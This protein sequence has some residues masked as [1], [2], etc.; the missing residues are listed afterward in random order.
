MSD[1]NDNKEYSRYFVSILPPEIDIEKEDIFYRDKYNEIINYFKLILT[2]SEDLEVYKY[3]KPKGVLLI[4]VPPGTDIINY[5]KLICSNYYLEFVELNNLE[6][7]KAPKD[8]FT[9]FN[10]ILE[11]F[12]KDIE[13]D[14]LRENEDKKQNLDKDNKIKLIL[15]NQ[16]STFNKLFKNESLLSNYINNIQYNQK[17]KGFI[18]NNLILVWLSYDYEEI[19]EVSDDLYEFFDLFIKI[20]LLNK[21]ERETVL[22]NFSEKNQKIAFDINAIVN[23]TENWEVQDLT[24]LLKIGIFKHYLKFEFNDVSNEITD[25]LIN[26]IET[27]EYISSKTLIESKNQKMDIATQEIQSNLSKKPEIDKSQGEF[28]KDQEA[29]IDEIKNQKVSEFM[30]NQLYENAASKNYNELL[31]IIDKLNNKEIIEDNDRK[32]IAKYP[33]ILNDTP[34]R[35]QLNLEKAKK[36]VDMLRQAFGK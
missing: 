29:I 28:I 19:V 1:L 27:G 6:I 22:R 34:N 14:K 20:P 2:H 3:V 30:L 17:K 13:I 23:Y 21:I 9:N 36:R 8:F 7:F 35:A 26:L 10:D 16:K 24:Q 15:I 32:L 31:L 12:N 25:I 18:N 11:N 33:F 5:L 4:N